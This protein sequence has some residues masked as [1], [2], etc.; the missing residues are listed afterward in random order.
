VRDAGDVHDMADAGQQRSPINR[1]REIRQTNAPHAARNNAIARR[2]ARRRDERM[3]GT[4]KG[5]DER[6]PD[7]A[8]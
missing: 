3:A 1:P 4:R 5:S 2:I 7:K 6:T 8:R